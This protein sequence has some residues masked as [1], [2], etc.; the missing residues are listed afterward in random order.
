MTIE[1]IAWGLGAGMILSFWWIDRDIKILLDQ[2]NKR[3]DKLDEKI[4][5]L[6]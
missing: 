3:L 4:D 5:N 1:N 6:E 2:M